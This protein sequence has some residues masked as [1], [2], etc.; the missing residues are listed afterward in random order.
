[1]TE[2]TT[3]PRPARPGPSTAPLR[4]LLQPVLGRVVRRNAA[5][6][7]GTF[8][9]IAPYR[10]AGFLIVPAICPSR[11]ICGPTR[12]RR[13][14]APC[15]AP[16]PGHDVLIEGPFLQLLGLV[17]GGGDGDTALFS[18]E[19]TISGNTEAVISLRNAVDDMDGSFARE[20]ADL[21]GPVKRV[22]LAGFCTD[23]ASATDSG[24]ARR[25]Y[26]HTGRRAGAA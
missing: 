18:R 9:R 15:R 16:L 2:T 4:A 19:L 8:A 26:R 10:Q 25:G 5:C 7:P 14:C 13:P 11:C 22:W 24:M 21:F 1:M 17:D 6:H 12:R 20:T 3:S 23:T